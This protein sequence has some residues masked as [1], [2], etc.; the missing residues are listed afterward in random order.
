MIQQT[1]TE[2]NFKQIKKLLKRKKKDSGR[3]EVEIL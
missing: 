1:Q 3:N 2:I